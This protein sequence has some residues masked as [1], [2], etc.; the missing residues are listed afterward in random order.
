MNIFRRD[1]STIFANALYLMVGTGLTAVFGFIF[2]IAIA[3]SHATSTVGLATVLLSVSTLIGFIGLVG[4]DAGVIRFLSRSEE[5]S[6]HINSAM[7]GVGIATCF[8]SLLFCALIPLVSPKLLFVDRHP[9]DILYF[10]VITVFTSWNTLTNTVFIAYRR[11]S[12]IVWVNIAVGVLKLALAV[13]FRHGGAITIFN[14]TGAV[15]IVNVALSLG[16]MAHAFGYRP[17]AKISSTTYIANVFYL[18]P[19]TVLPL[20]VTK[21]LGATEAAYFYIAY[22]IATLLY[23]VPNSAMQSLYAEGSHDPSSLRTNVKKAILTSG[24]ILLPAVVLLVVLCPLVLEAFG[25]AYKTGSV[26]LLR[27]FG[28][29]SFL[30]TLNLAL[31]IIFRITLHYRAV[32]LTNLCYAV[33][34]IGMTYVFIPAFGLLGV[35][36]AWAIANLVA[37]I[38]G[39]LFV[40]RRGLTAFG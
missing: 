6:K 18:V 37:I 20:I 25:S 21:E 11:T 26:D 32:I 40:K 17:T 12:Y 9:R 38:V 31:E 30:V 16:I 39:G 33:S 28:L 8:A 2:W 1:V 34:L 19:P 35:G 7:F 10:V 23:Q 24:V 13:T 4:L 36:V 5:P 14:I 27:L 22:T 29:S 15:Q 3:R